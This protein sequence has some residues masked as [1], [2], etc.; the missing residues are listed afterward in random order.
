[1]S[2]TEFQQGYES[3]LR[4]AIRET[5]LNARD[6]DADAAAFW[7]GA[8]SGLVRSERD[9]QILR[10]ETAPTQVELDLHLTGEGVTGHATK[11][12][13]LAVLIKKLS[14]STKFVA[15]EIA[16]A[17]K[18]S[19]NLLVEGV[20]PGSVRVV[21]RAPELPAEPGQLDVDPG[22]SADSK[23]LRR[24]ASLL[25]LASSDDLAGGDD[26][27]AAA[28]QGL[29]KPA[30]ESL[31]LAAQTVVDARWEVDGTVRRWREPEVQLRIT[32]RGAKHLRDTLG[33]KV[34]KPERVS[35][36]GT[37]DGFRRSV[38]VAFLRPD[39]EGAAQSVAVAD[40]GLFI[41]VARLAAEE[42]L[43]VRAAVE[44]W[45]AMRKNGQP[46]RVSRRLIHIEALGSQ[47][48]LGAAR[49]GIVSDAE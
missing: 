45:Q 10:E 3:L 28:V 46:G 38:G 23:A 47:E 29:P 37:L 21:I 2:A 9:E 30:R 6:A 4:D 41:K 20:A 22:E 40:A 42:D 31:R 8:L 11:A 36:V 7:W 14:E 26:P 15:R 32:S 48:T 1:M 33:Q 24:V 27:L 49:S 13:D 44:V 19:E 43:P 18:W 39:G 34:S 16:G 25:T 5:V 17:R 35:F 12:N